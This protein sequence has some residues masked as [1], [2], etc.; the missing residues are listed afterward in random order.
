MDESNQNDWDVSTEFDASW[1]D[2]FLVCRFVHELPAVERRVVR[3]LF[4][5]GC[6]TRGPE[7]VAFRM[8]MSVDEVWRLA[9]RAFSE[10]GFRAITEVAA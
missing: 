5:I 10:V 2:A 4:G 8:N 9:E 1:R 3:W 6:A 7:E